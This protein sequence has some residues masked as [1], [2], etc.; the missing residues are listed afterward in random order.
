VCRSRTSAP[1]ILAPGSR[2]FGL[3]CQ[4]EEGGTWGNLRFFDR[5]VL[6]QLDAGT[7]AE[8]FVALGALDGGVATLDLPGGRASQVAVEDLARRWSGLYE[9]LWQPPPT[10][11]IL[12]GPGSSSE[13]ARWL[14]QLLSQAPGLDFAGGDSGP[15]DTG[16][17]AALRRFQEGRGLVPDGV[18]GYRTLIQLHNVV[19]MPGIPKLIE[20]N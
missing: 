6:L 8:G 12:I 10:G 5:P 2:A 19:G 7:D 18:A 13:D 3:R 16:L 1:A 4:I 14:R 11:T 9:L 15:F 20:A 17:Q